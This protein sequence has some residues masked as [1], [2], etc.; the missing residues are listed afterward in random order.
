MLSFEA[1]FVRFRSNFFLYTG[2]LQAAYL[3][4]P[5][6]AQ[7]ASSARQTNNVSPLSLLLD[8]GVNSLEMIFFHHVTILRMPCGWLPSSNLNSVLNFYC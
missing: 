6:A 5:D 7:S 3:Y 4:A 1:I 8:A 2:I